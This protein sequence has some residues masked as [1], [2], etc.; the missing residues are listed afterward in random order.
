MDNS[1]FKNRKCNFKSLKKYGFRLKN[2]IYSYET[3]IM[4]SEFHLTV[5]INKSEEISTKLIDNQTKE[6]YLLHKNEN[7]T[8]SFIGEVREEYEQILNDIA[9]NCFSFEAFKTDAAKKI[10]TYI[11]E[12]YGDELEFLWD[13]APDC[14]IARRKDNKK[15]YLI[16]MTV[17]KD[18]L[19][20]K[21][22]K[23]VEVMNLTA[24]KEKVPQ[25]IDNKTFFPAYHMNKQS[26]FTILLENVDDYGQVFDLIDNSYLKVKG[27]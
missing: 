27:R 15:W 17:K 11:K 14:A 10:I 12:K 8:G 23:M 20:F 19:G 4:N 18:R 16:I 25:I 7:L 6:E 24:P 5:E 22:D 9:E 3:D 2:S 26:W 21:T 1:I 13:N